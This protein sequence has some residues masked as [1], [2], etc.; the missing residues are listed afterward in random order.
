MTRPRLAK[1]VGDAEG[2]PGV[3][4]ED[5][6]QAELSLIPHRKFG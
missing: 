6:Q 4:A 3:Q 1:P 2:R 5:A